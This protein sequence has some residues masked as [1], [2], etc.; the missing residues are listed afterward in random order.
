M[1]VKWIVCDVKN[2]MR[3]LFS[4]AQEKWGA[5]SK[6]PGFLGQLGGWDEKNKQEAC[7]LSLWKDKYSVDL[8]SDEVHDSITETNAQSRTY[9]SIYVEYFESQ[10]PMPGQ[11][12][13]LLDAFDKGEFIRV[14][15]CSVKSENIEHFYKAQKDVWIPGMQS[16]QGMLG[17]F[18]NRGIKVPEQFLV[19]TLWK[20]KEH[21]DHYSNTKVPLFRKEAD[22]SSDL[23]SIRGRFV[24]LDPK[25]VVLPTMR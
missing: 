18:F 21:H 14:A 12:E 9:D 25:W 5:I 8:F 4:T 2:E 24:H 13:D 15:E 3:G 23:T 7:I 11:C 19:T 17:G 10:L 1:L 20:N 22:V 6:C 16:S